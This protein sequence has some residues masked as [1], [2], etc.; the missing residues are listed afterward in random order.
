M[1]CGKGWSQ[2][3]NIN[4][5]RQE[6]GWEEEERGGG[7]GGKVEEEEEEEEAD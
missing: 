6:L 7:G 2:I 4:M 3:D 5:R 1:I